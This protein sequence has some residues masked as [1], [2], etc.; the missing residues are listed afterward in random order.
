MKKIPY[1]A[2]EQ[3]NK[4]PFCCLPDKMGHRVCQEVCGNSFG[5]D[6][7]LTPLGNPFGRVELSTFPLHTYVGKEQEN[8]IYQHCQIW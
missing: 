1:F 6:I 7:D 2:G 8:G 5:S 4:V 3:K